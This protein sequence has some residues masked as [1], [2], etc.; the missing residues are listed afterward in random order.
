MKNKPTTVGQTTKLGTQTFGFSNDEGCYNYCRDLARQAGT[1]ALLAE[2]LEDFVLEFKPELK[3]SMFS[4]ILDA[5]LSNINWY[6][7]AESFEEGLE[8]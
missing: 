3:P 8:D 6:E 7:I 4:D 1:T 5:G 2:R